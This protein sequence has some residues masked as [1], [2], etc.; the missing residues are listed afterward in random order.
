M[1]LLP[2]R[3]VL[4]HFLSRCRVQRGAARA[5]CEARSRRACE[6]STQ[7]NQLK[8]EMDKLE[9][10]ITKCENDIE[11]WNCHLETMQ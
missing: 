5:Q 11:L 10:H 4:Q 6:G 3:D 2:L 8:A 7:Y 1:R 9:N